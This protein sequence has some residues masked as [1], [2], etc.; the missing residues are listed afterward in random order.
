MEFRRKDDDVEIYDF[1]YNLVTMYDNIDE[2][3]DTDYNRKRLLCD[4]AHDLLSR[5]WPIITKERK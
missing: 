5:L 4:K 1:I 2:I 3:G